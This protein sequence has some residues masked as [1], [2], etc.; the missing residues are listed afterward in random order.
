M[1]SYFKT[2]RS[3]TIFVFVLFFILLKI[4]FFISAKLVPVANVQNLWN[5]VGILLSGS[6]F[7]NF[8]LAQVCLL[9]QA[10]AFNFLF[11]KANYHE[12]NSLIPGVYF[13]LV[14]SLIPQFNE[15]TVY[16]ILGFILLWMFQTLLLIT[17][18]ESTRFE[19]FNLGFT[20]G[21][22]VILNA[23]FIL[24][25]PFLLAMLFVMK[26]FR[27]NEYLMLLF[28]ILC[29]VYLAL[30]VSYLSDLTLNI[31]A[32]SLSKFHFFRFQRNVFHAIDFILTAAYLLFGFI[33]L[34]GIMYSTGFKRRKNINML[35]FFFIGMVT[36]VL[37]CGDL[38]ETAFMLLAIPVSIFL[39]L[40]MLR[41]RK[42]KLG[43]ILNA[44]FVVTIF[45][46][47]LIRIFK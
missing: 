26:P 43:E 46:L 9:L 45:I 1:L 13:V 29:P 17:I 33:S 20:G 41:I 22:L 6:I 10:I 14:T 7:L 2:Q 27:F 32:F 39:S 24:F 44:I 15:F 34:R 40:F 11:H 28:G 35:I 4:P 47:N 30:S 31:G 8:L 25:I 38:D 5:A 42:K 18:K 37:F 16:I 23:H 19:C 36:T 12:G 3:T 21:L